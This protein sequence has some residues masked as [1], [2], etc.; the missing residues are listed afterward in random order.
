[1]KIQ[2]SKGIELDATFA[3][4]RIDDQT[5]IL[6]ESR[7]GGKNAP[8]ERNRDYAQ[9]LELLLLRLQSLQAV[10]NQVLVESA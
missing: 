8:N 4:E 5:T 6:L 9:G 2:D 7:G 1:M 3:V 10:V